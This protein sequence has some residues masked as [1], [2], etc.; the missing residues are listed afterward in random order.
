MEQNNEEREQQIIK[1]LFIS[2]MS[3]LLTMRL[4][5]VVKL[6]VLSTTVQL[7]NQTKT[8]QSNQ[9]EL[10]SKAFVPCASSLQTP[11]HTPK[12]FAALDSSRCLPSTFLYL[13]GTFLPFPASDEIQFKTLHFLR[14]LSLTS[15]TRI[16]GPISLPLCHTSAPWVHYD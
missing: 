7:R 11:S 5:Q 2:L 9:D 1:D 14:V 16:L 4:K 6:F 15:K 10:H 8:I 12:S 13:P 3:S